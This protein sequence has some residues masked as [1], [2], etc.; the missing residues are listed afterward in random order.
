MTYVETKIIIP[1]SISFLPWIV[2][3][4]YK[5]DKRGDQYYHCAL[6]LSRSRLS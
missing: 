2:L 1:L 5:Y 3:E 6:N 4:V